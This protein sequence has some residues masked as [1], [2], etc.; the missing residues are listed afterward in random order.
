MQRSDE[1]RRLREIEEEERR[2]RWQRV[3]GELGPGGE[4]IGGG[5]ANP[6]VCTVGPQLSA[7]NCLPS[8]VSLSQLSALNCLPLTVALN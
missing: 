5:V 7:L 6:Q 8:I 3:I 4:Q 2:R 1:R